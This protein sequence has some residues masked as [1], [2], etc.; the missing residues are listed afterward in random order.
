M[1]STTVRDIAI[2]LV[3]VEILILNGLLVVLVWQIWRLVKMIQTEIKPVIKDSQE[4]VGTVKG[5]ADFVSTRVV[6]PFMIAS[7]RLAGL[8][9]SVQVI[10]SE[11]RSSMAAAVPERAPSKSEPPQTRAEQ[12]P[13]PSQVRPSNPSRTDQPPPG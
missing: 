13:N 4:T 6:S 8:R 2:I 5:T 1:V 12:G 3:A 10:Q 9:R 11:L 7:S